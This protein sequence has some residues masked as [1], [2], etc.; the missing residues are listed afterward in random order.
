LKFDSK[1]IL[2]RIVIIIS[3]KLTIECWSKLNTILVIKLGK[4]GIANVSS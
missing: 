3:N 2:A 1:P 4:N